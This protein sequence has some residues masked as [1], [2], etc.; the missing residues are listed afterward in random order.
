G[1]GSP[2]ISFSATGHYLFTGEAFNLT[3]TTSGVITNCT[4]SPTLPAGL[5]ISA[6]TCI[7]SGTATVSQSATNYTITASNSLGSASISIS[8]QISDFCT[9]CISSTFAGSGV[10]GG[11]DGTGTAARFFNPY[12]IA[13][14]G[15]GNIFI[16]ERDAY[17][18]R[19]ITTT[20]V[21]TT[22][23]GSGFSGNTDATGAS[24]SFNLPISVGTDGSGNLYI[25]DQGNHKIRKI[26]SGGV[27]TTFAGSGTQGS[28]D[29]TGT[30]ASFSSPRGIAVDGSGNVFVADC[31]NNKIRKITSGGVV[32]TFAG[33]GTQG[34]TD[35]TGTA[36]T[37]YCPAGLAVDSLGNVFVSDQGNN[38][39]RKITSGGVVTTLVGSGF[40]GN[41]NGIGTLA[42]FNVPIGLAVDSL[43]NIYVADSNNDR[44]RKITSAGLVS[45]FVGGP[46]GNTDGTG[47]TIKLSR[48]RG[49]V[50]NSSGHFYVTDDWNYKIRKIIP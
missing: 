23:A 48:P 7:I 38:K 9:T 13:I 4:T 21:V 45:T 36:A 40:S 27:V 14:D 41:T 30:S 5:S 8:I 18:I 17:V 19:K 6:S 28:S 44:I 42:S 50:I 26:T 46:S 43:G 3:P 15:S 20:G 34:S 10:Q 37:F 22:F 47:V 2:T 24:A 25:A 49:I 16:A 33:S 35:A 39:I 12:G 11:L 29:A 32:T 31:W 1:T